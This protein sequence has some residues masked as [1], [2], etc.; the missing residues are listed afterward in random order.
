MCWTVDCW[1]CSPGASGERKAYKNGCLQSEPACQGSEHLGHCHLARHLYERLLV[2]VWKSRMAGLGKNVSIGRDPQRMSVLEAFL[3]S[4]K[5][6]S[7]LFLM[8]PL[9]FLF[10]KE[11]DVSI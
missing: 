5:L 10:S 9:L 1:D 4:E 8:L 6:N 3:K 2:L 11:R 7:C